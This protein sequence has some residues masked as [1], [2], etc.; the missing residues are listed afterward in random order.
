MTPTSEVMEVSGR[1]SHHLISNL[2]LFI[3]DWFLLHL[4]I[5]RFH[6]LFKPWITWPLIG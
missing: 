2:T 4:R 3:S 5:H 1:T 6:R